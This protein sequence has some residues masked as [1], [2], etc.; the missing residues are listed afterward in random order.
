MKNL[1]VAVVSR[2]VEG[3][4]GKLTSMNSKGITSREVRN[5]LDV[6]SALSGAV[7]QVF[8]VTCVCSPGAFVTFSVDLGGGTLLTAM[9]G[10]AM[11]GRL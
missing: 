11:V 5:Y 8:T 10:N 4:C 7:D 3:L 2:S 6:L 1:H 9:W